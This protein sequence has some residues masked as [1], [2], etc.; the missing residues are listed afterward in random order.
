MQCG[1]NGEEEKTIVEDE[2]RVV[3]TRVGGVDRVDL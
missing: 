1:R 3:G 2:V